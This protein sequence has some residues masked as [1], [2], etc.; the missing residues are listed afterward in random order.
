MVTDFMK[1]WLRRLRIRYRSG[2][3]RI[4]STYQFEKVA[5]AVK[6]VEKANRPFEWRIFEYVCLI[7][8]T[9]SMILCG[10]LTNYSIGEYQYKISMILD[11]LGTKYILKEKRIV[12]RRR[13]VVLMLNI[14]RKRNDPAVLF[15]YIS[16]HYPYILDAE[17]LDWTCL[18]DFAK[19][20]SRNVDFREPINYLSV[21]LFVMSDSEDWSLLHAHSDRRHYQV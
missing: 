21:L 1:R 2:L 6:V 16:K 5:E 9:P 11:A 3:D 14:L 19:E 15:Q 8:N 12:L 13:S 4:D 18:H 20:Y 10:R 7:A 17:S